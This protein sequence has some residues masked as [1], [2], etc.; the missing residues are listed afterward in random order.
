MYKVAIIGADQLG[1]RHLQGLKTAVSPLS[2]SVVDSSNESLQIAKERY[3]TVQA[4]GENMP[5]E[6]TFFITGMD[7]S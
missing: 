5:Q 3:D 2:I 7:L 1:S 6:I 4:V